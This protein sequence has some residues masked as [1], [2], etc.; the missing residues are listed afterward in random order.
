MRVVQS[1]ILLSDKLITKEKL[2]KAAQHLELR[3]R[4]P[5][6][7]PSLAREKGKK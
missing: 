7:A 1:L 2:K 3:I 5:D 6:S 4:N